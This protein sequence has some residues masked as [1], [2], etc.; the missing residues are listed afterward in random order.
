MQ[1]KVK[2]AFVLDGKTYFP[3]GIVND[4][5]F[6]GRES[7][8]NNF[9][10]TDFLVKDSEHVTKFIPEPVKEF[11]MPLVKEIKNEQELAKIF[12]TPENKKEGLV[13]KVEVSRV[14]AK[15]TETK[16]E[17]PAPAKQKG[18]ASRS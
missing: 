12:D 11:K 13:A 17:V 9:L 7:I 10:K 4:S 5:I 1:Y 14:K 3:G 16:V 15:A 18:R 6:I 2:Y 8:L